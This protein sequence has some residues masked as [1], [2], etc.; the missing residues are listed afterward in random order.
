[1]MT[2]RKKFSVH[3]L[4]LNADSDAASVWCNMQVP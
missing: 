3:D 4:G 1:M 2:R